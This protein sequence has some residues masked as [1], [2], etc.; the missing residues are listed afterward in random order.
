M[1]FYNNREAKVPHALSKEGL[2]EI[3]KEITKSYVGG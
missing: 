1:N 2:E 3:A